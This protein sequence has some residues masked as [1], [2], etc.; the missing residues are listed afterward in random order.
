MSFSEILIIL[1]QIGC[2]AA[3]G[4]VVTMLLVIIYYYIKTHWKEK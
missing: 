3:L 1:L 4:S 2:I